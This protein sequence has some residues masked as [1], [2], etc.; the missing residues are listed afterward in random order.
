MP[1]SY[2]KVEANDL[3]KKKKSR[4]EK[5]YLTYSWVKLIFSLKSFCIFNTKEGFV[6]IQLCDSNKSQLAVEQGCWWFYY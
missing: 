5:K 2:M 4:E 3:A 1:T 6:P